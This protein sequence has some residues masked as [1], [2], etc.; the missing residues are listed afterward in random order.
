MDNNQQ[1]TEGGVQQPTARPAVAEATGPE[2]PLVTDA[3]TDLGVN[4]PGTLNVASPFTGSD[5]SMTTPRYAGGN[6]TTTEIG[7]KA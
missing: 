6:I 7:S 3:K 5:I 2:A 1:G 4:A